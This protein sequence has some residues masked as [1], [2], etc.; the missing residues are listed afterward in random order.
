VQSPYERVLGAEL[1]RLHPRLR[2]YFAAIPAG[3]HGHGVGVFERVGTPRRWLW[4]VLSAFRH[5]GVLFPGWHHDV[6]FSVVNTP[7]VGAQGEPLVAATRHFDFPAR[8][9]AMVD[10]IS[11]VGERAVLV[12]V[13]GRP[14]LIEAALSV[15]VRDGALHMRSTAV[16]LRLA[17]LRVRVPASISPTVVLVERFDDATDSQ[18]VTVELS[19]PLLGR[20]YEYSGS[21]HYEIRSG[22]GEQ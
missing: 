7:G 13:L 17:G 19:A 8:G 22:D 12:D 16:V 2:D 5:R 18:H 6:P 9:R 14:G 21:F 3:C 1:A 10:S 4:P 20:L 15:A 11:A